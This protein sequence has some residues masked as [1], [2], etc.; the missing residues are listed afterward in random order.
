MLR[1]LIFKR[2]LHSRCNSSGD[3][4]VQLR[5]TLYLNTNMAPCLEPPLFKACVNTLQSSLFT[6]GNSLFLT[7][8]GLL[9]KYFKMIQHVLEMSNVWLTVTH[10]LWQGPSEGRLQLSDFSRGNKKNQQWLW[11]KHNSLPQAI[12]TYAWSWIR[13]EAWKNCRMF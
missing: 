4:A 7:W 5:G 11:Q 1:V 6:W 9:A 10:L 3:T 8:Y 12:W 2:N 13:D